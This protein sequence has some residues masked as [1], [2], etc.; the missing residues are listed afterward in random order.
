MM[1]DLLL[2]RNRRRRLCCCLLTVHISESSNN[3]EAE[4]CT[5]THWE[6]L[7][8]SISSAAICHLWRW[9]LARRS[10]VNRVVGRPS[11]I[12]IVARPSSRHYSQGRRR[13]ISPP[14]HRNSKFERFVRRAEIGTVAAANV[15]L[16]RRQYPMSTISYVGVGGWIWNNNMDTILYGIGCLCWCCL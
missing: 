13:H 12:V 15:E 2:R 1:M 10:S 4:M 8:Y 11:I 7:V 9:A 16:E 14:R 5:S 6:V 3:G